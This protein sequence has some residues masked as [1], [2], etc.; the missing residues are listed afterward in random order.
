[1]TMGI[2]RFNALILMAALFL[3][4]SCSSK[5]DFQFSSE[6]GDLLYKIDL[7]SL[8]YSLYSREIDSFESGPIISCSNS[9]TV[10][11]DGPFYL[12]IE[13]ANL[14][15][16][17]KR[18]RIA[19]YISSNDKMECSFELMVSNGNISIIS[20]FC[21]YFDN[22]PWPKFILSGDPLVIYATAH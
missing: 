5:S 10:C 9:R 7:N 16:M 20:F 8:T 2:I 13:N 21:K 22:M 3:I 4:V 18:E 1:M 17:L 6:R 14:D 12:E 11:Y 15:L 19:N